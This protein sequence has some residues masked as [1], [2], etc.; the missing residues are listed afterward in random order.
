MMMPIPVRPLAAALLAAGLIA[1]TAG[2]VPAATKIGVT[3]A[4][5]PQAEA[6]PPGAERRVL[7]VGID[8]QADERVVTT[9]RGQVQ[10]LFLDG[11]TMSIGP[12]SEVVLDRFVYDPDSGTGDLAVTVGRGVFRFVGGRISKSQ[13]VQIG[14][15]TATIGIR[16]GIATLTVAEDGSVETGFLFGER[17]TVTSAGVTQGTSQPGTGISVQAGLPPETPRILS[18][19]EITATL[20]AFQGPPPAPQPEAGAEGGEEGGDPDSA[21][22]ESG[23]DAS[24]GA[25]GDGAPPASAAAGAGSGDSGAVDSGQRTRDAVNDLVAA[26]GEEADE[27]EEIVEE[28]GPGEPVVVL[29]PPPEPPP[30]SP[31]PPAPPPLLPQ[32]GDGR[33]L[34]GPVYVTFDPQTLAVPLV[35]ANTPFLSEVLVTGDRLGV[36]TTTGEVFDFPW[37]P[38]TE[39]G[40]SQTTSTGPYPDF[41]GRMFTAADSSFWRVGG[42]AQNGGGTDERFLLFGGTPTE[43][44]QLPVAGTVALASGGSLGPLPF[45]G[46]QVPFGSQVEG[47][48]L[49]PLYLRHG[50]GITAAQRAA[51][52]T[53]P[54]GFQ[55]SVMIQ[56][57]GGAQASFL[58]GAVFT[59]VEEGA[60][61]SGRIALAG[62]LVG[63]G[64]PS[65]EE[66][67]V[68]YRSWLA[69]ADAGEH[70]AIFGDSG[71]YLVVDSSRL[72]QDG[73]TIGRQSAA[74]LVD[75]PAASGDTGSSYATLLAQ[76]AAT[77][78]TGLGARR[79]TRIMRGFTGGAGTART[80]D[81]SSS[82]FTFVESK[83]GIAPGD[84]L[85]RT[86]AAA[87]SVTVDIGITR[88]GTSDGRT[89]L[90]GGANSAT[91]LAPASAFIDNN[92]Y[93]AVDSPD[94][95]SLLGSGQQVAGQDLVLVT[96]QSLDVGQLGLG[97][98]PCTCE[99]LDWG[100]WSGNLALPGGGEERYHLASWVAGELAELANIPT[101]GSAS[102]AGQLIGTVNAAAGS[103]VAGSQMGVNWNFGQRT[104]QFNVGSFD[105]AAFAGQLTSIDGRQVVGTAQNA[106]LGRTM[107]VD[108]AFFQ[109]GGDPV[110]ALGGSFSVQGQSYGAAGTFALDRQP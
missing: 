7:H 55:T 100:F 71:Q 43:L 4:V 3:A 21:L 93:I 6:A 2:T 30:P 18:T 87:D 95:V 76:P 58:S 78:P 103:H 23:V 49:S 31:P 35:A 56:G 108:G 13:P 96:A 69:S 90:V 16:G 42:I 11:S 88:T 8:M 48:A 28:A 44:A 20:S 24:D 41:Q 75:G 32:A 105:S 102:Y 72:T 60:P 45:F 81:G 39:T 99:Y 54:V 106:G 77:A 74:M 109:G 52:Q 110:A 94:R 104:G 79:D 64:R 70:A 84:V 80:A 65:A 63:S 47:V 61:G 50:P 5:N 82:R 53:P 9:A 91:G 51:G 86:D 68:L 19:Q 92:R 10:L 66:G 89:L 67:V 73:A 40:V 83:V 98:T 22:A 12:D 14:T 59:L 29:P 26:I 97:G 101:S 46:G 62:R 34:R 25:D 38:G 37:S 15:G 36:T 33:L 85:V 27:V 1:G 17:M 107:N 57:T